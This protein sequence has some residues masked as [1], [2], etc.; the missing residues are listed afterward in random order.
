MISV[1]EILAKES[2]IGVGKHDPLLIDQVKNEN[3]K[4]LQIHL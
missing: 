3:Q 4:P 1:E 2:D